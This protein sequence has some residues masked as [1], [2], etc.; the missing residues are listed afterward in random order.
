V[1]TILFYMSMTYTIFCLKYIPTSEQV[2]MCLCRTLGC[3]GGKVCCR[4]R[5]FLGG[6]G[7]DSRTVD[8]L[9]ASVSVVI[10]AILG[11]GRRFSALTGRS[12]CVLLID[13]NDNE[14]EKQNRCNLSDEH[15]KAEF[16]ISIIW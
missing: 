10:L 9:V 8:N 13:T 1:F 14:L 12:S 6:L 5:R 16:F 2:D 11:S 7:E 3:R 4:V 15:T